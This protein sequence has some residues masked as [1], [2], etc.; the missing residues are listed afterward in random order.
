MLEDLRE[1]ILTLLEERVERAIETIHR[2][3]DEKLALESANNQLRDEL[4]H[5]DVQIQNLQQRNDELNHFEAELQVLQN[6]REQ[7]RLDVDKEKAEVRERLEGLMTMLN[8]VENRDRAE[9]QEAEQL[10][11]FDDTDEPPDISEAPDISEPTDDEEEQQ[12]T[13]QPDTPS[14][15]LFIPTTLVQQQ[16][17]EQSSDSDDTDDDTDEETVFA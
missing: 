2:L 14:D 12:E 8:N 5:R 1:N 4:D 6:E 17:A 10:S 9:T 15:M 7:E 13:E 16:E 11:A 3:R